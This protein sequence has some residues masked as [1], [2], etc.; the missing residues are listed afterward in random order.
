MR[1][2]LLMSRLLDGLYPPVCV[3]CNAVLREGRALCD[4]CDEQL[5][6]LEAPFCQCCGE[7][8]AGRIEAAATCPRCLEED[9]AYEFVRPVLRRDDGALELIHR[10]K[11]QCQI[12]L[13]GELGRIAAEA[14]SDPRLIQA[15]QERWP[16]VPVPLHWRRQ[17]RRH[18]NQ[19]AEIARVMSR[20]C[21]LPVLAAL[22]RVRATGTQTALSRKQRR[23]NLRGAFAL[24][25]HG[26]RMLQR[27]EAGVVLVDD[28][29]TTGATV[30]E[31]TRVLRRAGVGQ[32]VVVALMRG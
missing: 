11:Y 10:F 12:H 22:K 8:F 31:C 30:E 20:H 28:V 19:S 6:R 29:M 14:F 16:L 24:S 2:G 25:R 32:V 4:C 23:E 3:Q 27:L 15:R 7:A 18:F 9:P 26:R 17:R 5:P 1:T 21:E 13:A